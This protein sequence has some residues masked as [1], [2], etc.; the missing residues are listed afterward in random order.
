MLGGDV[1]LYDGLC[2]EVANSRRTFRKST[3]EKDESGKIIGWHGTRGIHCTKIANYIS[4]NISEFE[5]L[6]ASY[7]EDDK[8]NSFCFYE[9]FNQLKSGKINAY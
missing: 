4:I 7:A 6:C 3:P 8:S 5:N 2:M 9:I 1:R